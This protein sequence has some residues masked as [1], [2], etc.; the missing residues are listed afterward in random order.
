LV[1]AAMYAAHLHNVVVYLN[2]GIATHRAMNHH[3]RFPSL[4]HIQP[5]AKPGRK[6]PLARVLFAKDLTY[7]TSYL[8]GELKILKRK[9]F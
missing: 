9:V 1:I 2:D 3:R 6:L 8:A 4:S 5:N 7:G